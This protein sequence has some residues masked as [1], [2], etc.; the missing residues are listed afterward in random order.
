[1]AHQGRKIWGLSRQGVSDTSLEVVPRILDSVTSN[2]SLSL[3][4][5]SP[6][7]STNTSLPFLNNY[8]HPNPAGYRGPLDGSPGNVDATVDRTA[9][10]GRF[11]PQPEKRVN[12]Q[13]QQQSE[14]TGEVW[15]FGQEK[16]S[17][18]TRGQAEVR[19]HEPGPVKWLH[20]R[21]GDFGTKAPF[22]AP[23]S[24]VTSTFEFQPS[25]R[26]PD[27]RPTS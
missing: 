6:T 8:S 16:L 13:Q 17:I 15:P 3:T 20:C 25:F 21:F 19:A 9:A 26:Y 18:M 5:P 14:T 1:M 11:R 4:L 2:L 24:S 12:Q 7:M 27:V 22:A 10:G 23:T